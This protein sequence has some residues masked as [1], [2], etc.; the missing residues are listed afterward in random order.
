[1]KLYKVLGRDCGSLIL[2]PMGIVAEPDAADFAAAATTFTS[3]SLTLL[4]PEQIK[5][6]ANQDVLSEV[7][8]SIS[9][10]QNLSTS[11]AKDLP[12]E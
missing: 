2:Q 12:K 5:R 10:S 11:F 9:T 3:T 8:T 4:Q 1:M 7:G 6:E